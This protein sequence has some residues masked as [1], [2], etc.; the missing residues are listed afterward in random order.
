[1]RNIEAQDQNNYRDQ[2]Y[3]G[4]NQDNL[5]HELVNFQDFLYDEA[6]P[7]TPEL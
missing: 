4:F 5:C 2:N 6:S 3:E 7:L 1:M